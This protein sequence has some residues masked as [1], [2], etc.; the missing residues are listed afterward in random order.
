MVFRREGATI[1]SHKNVQRALAGKKGEIEMERLSKRGITDL[2]M[3]SILPPNMVFEKRLELIFGGY[4]IQ[5]IPQGHA[6]TDGDII[7]YLPDFKTIIAGGLINNKVI[8]F[9]LESHTEA[10]I[11]SLLSVEDYKAEII[12][13]GF[14]P[15]G[16]KPTAIQM[17]HYLLDLKQQIILH[18]SKGRSSKESL[19][20]ISSFIKNKYSNWTAQ[21]HNEENIKKVF[22]EYLG[23]Q[24][25]KQSETPL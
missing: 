11:Q 16:E 21:E 10:W 18:I 17:R 2:K 14:G 6:L 9:M 4:H 3:K 20:A 1:I 15:V 13:P 7:V 24:L 19:K 12:I 8:P 23:L 25:K 22:K 5:L